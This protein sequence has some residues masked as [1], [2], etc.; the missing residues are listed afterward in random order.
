MI[1]RHFNIISTSSNI[2]S[3]SSQH[4]FN[5]ISKYEVKN[6]EKNWIWVWVINLWSFLFLKKITWRELLISDK[7]HY[8]YDEIRTCDFY[9]TLN[10]SIYRSTT[11]VNY[12]IISIY[13][14]LYHIHT[15]MKNRDQAESLN[16]VAHS[17]AESTQLRNLL[18]LKSRS[19]LTH[20]KKS[21]SVNQSTQST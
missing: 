12:T 1:L 10:Y 21:F 8:A 20:L 11:T 9:I 15:S 6:I 4:H 19:H 14:T 16:C 13:W 7:L 17:A 5:I 2:I 18:I 3:T